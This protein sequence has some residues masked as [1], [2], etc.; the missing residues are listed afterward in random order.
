MWAAFLL[1]LGDQTAIAVVAYCLVVIGIGLIIAHLVRLLD[2]IKPSLGSRLSLVPISGMSI[3]TVLLLWTWLK[4]S[5][6]TQIENLQ[7]YE[8]GML[9]SIPIIWAVVVVLGWIAYNL[10]GI[11]GLK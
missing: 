10:D 11:R 2:R 8:I 3:L 1:I 9:F 7:S 5:I 4:G 6:L